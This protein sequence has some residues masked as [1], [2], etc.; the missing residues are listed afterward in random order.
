[1]TPDTG[2]SFIL[3]ALQHIKSNPMKVMEQNKAFPAAGPA[4]CTGIHRDF[5]GNRHLK[6]GASYNGNIF[7]H[8][9]KTVR[10]IA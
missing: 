7:D 4:R 5:P 10:C 8:Y 3:L 1:M 6:R 9:F 2:L